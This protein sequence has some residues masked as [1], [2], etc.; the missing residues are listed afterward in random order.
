MTD[1]DLQALEAGLARANASFSD[2]ARVLDERSRVDLDGLPDGALAY[3]LAEHTAQREQTQVVIVTKDVDQADR[4][5]SDLRF[6]AAPPRGDREILVLPPADNSPYLD[7]LPDRRAEMER[8]AVLHHLAT[9]LPWRF[10][11]VPAA[12]LIRRLPP[13]VAIQEASQTFERGQNVD[14]DGLI[15]ALI[16][17]GYVRVPLAEDPGTFSA[18]GAIIDIFCPWHAKPFRL[19]LDDE[20]VV[21]LKTFDPDDQKPLDALPLARLHPAREVLASPEHLTRAKQAVRHLCDEVNLPTTQAKQLLEELERGAGFI[22]ATGFLPGFYEGLDTVLD[23]VSKPL[24]VLADPTAAARAVA[25]ELDHATADHEARVGRGAPSFRLDDHYLEAGELQQRLEPHPTVVSHRLTFHGAPQDDSPLSRY[26]SI[27]DGDPLRLAVE[28]HA[29]LIAQ[30]KNARTHRETH[31]ALAPLV[32]KIRVWLDAGQQVTLTARTH[33]QA[34]RLSALLRDYGLDPRGEARLEIAVGSLHDGFAW[35]ERGRVFVTEEEVFGTRQHKRSRRRD[36]RV[37]AKRFLEDLRTLKVGDF[38]VHT[39]HGVGKYLGLDHKALA[40]SQLERM[41]GRRAQT[42]EVLIVEYLGGDKLFLPV[43]RLGSIQKFSGEEGRAPKLDR[44]GGLTFDKKKARVRRAVRQMAE[45]LLKLYAERAAAA[46][47]PLEA[48]GT[49][50]SEFEATFPFEE[51]PD[52]AKAIDDVLEDLEQPSPMDRLVCGD[53]GFGKTEVALRA[54]FRVALSGRQV[55]VLCPTT[56]LAQQHYRSFAER[57]ADYPIRVRV[58]SRFVPRAEQT[59]T[60]ADLKSGKVDI[61]IGTHRLLSKD[62]HFA[63][64]GLLVVDEEQRFGVKHKERIK[65][66]RTQVDVLTLSAT[67][68][69]R[70][71]QLAIGGMRDLSL[72]ATA[73]ADRRAVRTFVCRWDDQLIKEAIER[74]LSRGGQ[75]FFVYNRIEGLHERAQR[76]QELLPQARIAVAHGRMRSDALERAMTDFVEGAYDVLCST[77]IIESGLDIPRANTIL[78]DHANA[79]GLSQLYQLRGRV[80]RSNQRAF[81]YLI[82][83]PPGELTDESRMRMEALERFSDLGAG[84]HV[85]TLDMELRGAGDLLGAEQSGNASLVG[86]DLFVDML[87]EAVAE[88]RGEPVVSDVDPELTIEVEHY[89]PDDYIEDVGLRLSFYRRFAMAEDEQ[90]ID[91]LAIEME[92]RFG[93]PPEQA[94]EFVRVM[95]LRPELRALRALGCE[96]NGGRVTLHLR[97]DTP[98]DPAKLMP[99]ISKRGSGWKLTADRKLTR[100]YDEQGHGPT[101]PVQ[102]VHQLFQELRPLRRDAD[103]ADPD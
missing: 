62:V 39:E 60:L 72:I 47:E 9:G 15:E 4:L 48:S 80:G 8:L 40:L 52:Q 87:A 82:T 5:E 76:I 83:P 44:L 13:R 65:R 85:A 14:R 2:I 86:F 79:L 59:K 19:E 69:P 77:A 42:V 61:V 98:L 68:I 63:D 71:L 22:G 84:F 16:R 51:T 73:P 92:D 37:E 41:Q 58:L 81:C 45:E 100:H 31:K 26:E 102:R 21:S 28:D 74:E 101:E 43:T 46:R 99:L 55:A 88:L 25:L 103:V 38:V 53:V 35:L 17:G 49:E 57:M 96:A 94:R 33:H 78:I 24:V 93:P 36:K 56:V 90:G 66:L 89:L 97:Q 6:F 75:V 91:A 30:L 34:E 11:L 54:A 20:R 18:R 10:L 23:Y 95:A 50:Y 12:A 29:P 32:D 67:P 27:E 70:T 1:V 3:L 64:L 7:V